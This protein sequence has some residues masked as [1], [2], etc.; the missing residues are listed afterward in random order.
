M[1][2]QLGYEVECAS[3]G[4]EAIE[5]FT[6]ARASG[7]GFAGVLLDLTVPGRM[8]G[9]EAAVELRKIDPSAKLVVSSGYADIP[10][11]SE[12]QTYGFDDVIRKPYT[13][14]ELSD[15]LTR[16]IGTNLT[17]VKTIP[18]SSEE[19]DERYLLKAPLPAVWDKAGGERVSVIL[20]AGAV[21][22]SSSQR[23]TTLLGMVGVYWK[24]RHY[25]VY[26]KDLFQKA[27]RV[28]TA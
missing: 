8:G 18:R 5:L 22:K 14:A 17:E 21:L 23:S 9:K 11:L 27:E 12:F 15:V 26:P 24:G 16:V 1:M 20:P 6:R 2:S 28:S 13:L 19:G 10:I 4:A 25:S 7:R 3:D